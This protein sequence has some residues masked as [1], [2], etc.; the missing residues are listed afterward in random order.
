MSCWS[1]YIKFLSEPQVH[2]FLALSLFR[3]S[4][5]FFSLPITISHFPGLAHF[6]QSFKFQVSCFLQEA[7]WSLLF[8]K[9]SSPLLP[10]HTV[11]L[12]YIIPLSCNYFSVLPLK[13]KLKEEREGIFI[14]PTVF[15][16]LRTMR[17]WCLSNDIL[18]NS[19][20][21]KTFSIN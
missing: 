6:Q 9:N 13:W 20:L 3:P 1:R 19:M 17:D 15:P 18:E 14:L 16:A 4:P 2:Q 12:Y 10:W 7:F 21:K 5:R 11:H 8:F